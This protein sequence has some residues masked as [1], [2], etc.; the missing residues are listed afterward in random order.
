MDFMNVVMW[1]KW[2][3]LMLT[4]SKRS[5]KEVAL[6]EE[7]PSLGA[8]VLVELVPE[9]SRAPDAGQARKVGS[10]SVKINDGITVMVTPNSKMGGYLAGTIWAVGEGLLPEP[11]AMAFNEQ[12]LRSMLEWWL[13]EGMNSCHNDEGDWIVTNEV[14]RWLNQRGAIVV[15]AL[16]EKETEVGDDP[17]GDI[18]AKLQRVENSLEYLTSG[19]AAVGALPGEVGLLMKEKAYLEAELEKLEQ[20]AMIGENAMVERWLDDR[21]GGG[22]DAEMS[23]AEEKAYLEAELMEEEAHLAELK[24]AQ[25]VRRSLFPEAGED[26]AIDKSKRLLALLLLR[27]ESLKG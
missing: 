6:V 7:E 2:L 11:T 18:E 19:I 4:A 14:S 17:M 1:F 15:E 22:D 12:F 16:E 8:V 25:D 20:E 9:Y 10:V 21:D 3:A 26:P 13:E 24:A 23:L 5:W 27:M